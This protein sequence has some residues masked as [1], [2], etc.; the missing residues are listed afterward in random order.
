MNR[1]AQAASPYLRQH[2]GNPVDWYP[3]GEE[4]FRRAREEDKPIFLSIG[5]STCHWCHVMA[6]ESFED[7]EIAALLNAHF[8]AV[9]VDREERPD[10]DSIYMAVCQAFTGSGGW[11]T[12]VFITADQRPFFAGTYFPKTSRYGTPG[13]K[14]LL[15]I[16]ADRWKN[17]RAELL[18]A[19]DE[20]SAA[21]RA[22]RTPAGGPEEALLDAALAQYRDSFDDVYGGFGSAPK[23][24]APHNLDFLLRMYETRGDEQ[25]LQMAEK[26]LLHMYSGGMFDHIGY[27][28]CRYSTD[29]RFL[30][31][32]FEKMLYDNALLLSAYCHAFRATGNAFYRGVAERIAD[33]LRRELLAPDGG[34][35]S[36]QDADSDGEEGKYYLFTPAELNEVLG[37][38]QG[39]A[40]AAAYGVTAAGN[41]RGRSIPN[42]LR[43]GALLGGHTELLPALREYRRRRCRLHT[44]DKI[45][46]VWN[47]LAVS[48]F[49]AL[50]R[51][52]R[53]PADL[54]TAERTM[55]FLTE[56]LSDGD[57][58]VR[59]PPRRARAAG[60]LRLHRACAARPVRRH[61]A[62]AVS[63]AGG[64][65]ASPRGRFVL[66]RRQ[67]RLFPQ[68]ARERKTAVPPEGDLRRRAAERKRGYDRA[69][70]P[71]G[72]AAARGRVRRD[73][74]KAARL[75]VRRIRRL[76]DGTRGVPVR[77][78]RAARPAA[79]CDRRARRERGCRGAAV[80]AAAGGRRARPARADEDVS[81]Q[82]RKNHLLRLPRPPLPAARQPAGGRSAVN[83]SYIII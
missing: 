5:Y 22:G 25:A 74:G 14:E 45:L 27:G 59:R 38:A 44:D 73:G 69:S 16:I 72:R 29:R 83:L 63:R 78:V 53:S 28:F 8:V 47:A 32:H 33:Y 7:R 23:F 75:Y 3:W 17:D 19:A 49:C 31:P 43:G 24:P 26:T 77:A 42:L 35:Y 70:R 2:A 51:I 10:I 66:R 67:R 46:T 39:E 9:K 64:T 58:L 52:T 48:A 15:E 1:L 13:L 21:L 37:Q 36:A 56:R 6:R 4:A 76:P 18:R 55:A 71:A 60:R 50:Y 62:G 54:E 79:A 68:R 12:T 57:A 80:S 82:G 40:F 41:F 61:A 81:A 34:F 11:P 30:V 20:A 65:A